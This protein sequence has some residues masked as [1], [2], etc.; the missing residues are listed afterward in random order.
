MTDT[1]PTSNSGYAGQQGLNDDTSDFNK[2]VFLVQQ[3]LGRVRTMV[4]V[5]IVAVTNAGGV[6]PVGFV[7]AVP[8]V[9]QINGVG[10]ATP[11]A[12]IFNLPYTRL[13]GG[14]NA[15][16]IDP[17]IG[18]IGWAAIADRDISAVKSTKDTANPGSF[19]RFDLADGVYIGGVLNGTPTQYL[20]FSSAG[21]DM[22]SP[23]QITMTVGSHGIVI[24]PSAVIIDGK[25][26]LPHT[27]GNVTPGGGNSG[28]VT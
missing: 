12:T 21:I 23:T 15:V 28:G 20:Q 18:D 13:Q 25:P 26:F 14:E 8:L 9:N 1:T 2:M 3:I 7:D 10:Q 16:I 5:K 22:V 19:R 17:Q 4:L 24:T 11:H 6:A 27:H